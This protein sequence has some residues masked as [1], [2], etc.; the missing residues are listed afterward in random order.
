MKRI[1]SILMLGI[2]FLASSCVKKYEQ[3]TPN[4]TILTTVRANEWKT[5]NGGK[6][7]S[8]SLSVPEIDSYL[9]ENGGVLVY[10][11]FTGGVY[12][13]IPQVYNGI[14]Y[15]YSHATGKIDIDIQDSNGVDVI[16]P[17]GA[18]TIKIVLIDSY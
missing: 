18:L 7:Y 12:E 8:V 4:Q 16:N 17:P 14:A 10:A 1:L 9:N 2:V 5:I 3:V 6:T 15:S 13:Q 11:S